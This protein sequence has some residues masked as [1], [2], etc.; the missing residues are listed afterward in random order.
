[1]AK[2]KSSVKESFDVGQHLTTSGVKKTF[3]TPIY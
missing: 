1:M 3:V 2:E